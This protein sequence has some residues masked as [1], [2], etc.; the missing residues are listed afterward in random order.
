ME[1]LDTWPRIGYN[2]KGKGAGP[3]IYS[4]DEIK[5]IAAPVAAAHGVRSMRLFGSY[6]RGQATEQSD[7]DLRIDCGKVTDLFAWGSLL[8]DLQDV[9]RKNLDLVTT[10]GLDPAFIDRIRPDE[11]LIYEQ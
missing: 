11:V 7:I 3:M 5:K 1:G 4:I 6:A 10:E 8:A 9:F 2:S